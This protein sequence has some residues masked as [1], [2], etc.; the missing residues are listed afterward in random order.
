MW[1][2]KNRTEPV[3]ALERAW[4]HANALGRCAAKFQAYTAAEVATWWD[5][6]QTSLEQPHQQT[7]TTRRNTCLE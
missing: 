3:A 7:L 1:I 5:T 4:H 6:A 2:V